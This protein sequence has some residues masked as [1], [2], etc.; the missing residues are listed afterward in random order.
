MN[1]P[2][3]YIIKELINIFKKAKYAIEDLEL[4]FRKDFFPKHGK[5]TRYPIETELL[6]GFSA[7]YS[8]MTLPVA[9]FMLDM[10]LNIVTSPWLLFFS[11][12]GR[13]AS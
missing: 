3:Q 10:P 9:R 4:G 13:S 1:S 7:P 8:K 2:Q 5:Q 11:L 12:F 6:R